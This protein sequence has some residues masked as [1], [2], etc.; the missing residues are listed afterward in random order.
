MSPDDSTQADHGKPAVT[1]F[2]NT[3]EFRW[4]QREI[5]YEQVYNLAFADQPLNDGDIARIE[6]SR[7]HHGGGAG[8]LQPGQTVRV[9]PN[10]VFD[11]YVTVRS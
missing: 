11:V 2:V 7:G 5:S 10:M 6:Y 8:T 4:E 9:K 3:R 1:I